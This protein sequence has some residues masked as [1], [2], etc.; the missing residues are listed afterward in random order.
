MGGFVCQITNYY[1]TFALLFL[2]YSMIPA[3]KATPPR[4]RI[5][6][7]RV[8][9]CTTSLVLTLDADFRLEPDPRLDVPLFNDEP[10]PRLDVPL[11][12]DEPLPSE[13]EPSLLLPRELLPRVL[14]PSEPFPREELLLF[15]FE[16]LLLLFHLLSLLSKSGS[17]AVVA[18]NE[19][20]SSFRNT[21]CVP[22]PE[23]IA[24]I[25]G[26]N[27]CNGTYPSFRAS[28]INSNVTSSG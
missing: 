23:L 25:I 27:T 5:A 4:R 22:V 26:T 19:L 24:S 7:H 1:F 14:F 18:F 15:P 21:G 20:Q 17:S 9:F 3:S 13:E 6:A 10:L 16:F 28:G 2:L 12:N 8:L 11:F